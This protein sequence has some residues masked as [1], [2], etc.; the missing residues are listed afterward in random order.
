MFKPV[1]SESK[2]PNIQAIRMAEKKDGN[3]IP[4][5]P[6]KLIRRS[7]ALPLNSAAKS[8]RLKPRIRAR[9]MAAVARTKVLGKVS[10]KICETSFPWDRNEVRR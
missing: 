5:V 9:L 6:T 10:L 3:D 1:N 7:K 8:P 2:K 4:K